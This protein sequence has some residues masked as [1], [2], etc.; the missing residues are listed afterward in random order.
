MPQ[1][2]M[3]VYLP[4]NQLTQLL[5]QEYFTEISYFSYKITCHLSQMLKKT[6][7]LGTNAQSTGSQDK[8]NELTTIQ[9]EDW[10]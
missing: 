4:F 5:A 10:Q 1:Y 7:P 8:N 9:V 2:Q 6:T 3:L